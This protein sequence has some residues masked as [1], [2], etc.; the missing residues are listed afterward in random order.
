MSLD[1]QRWRRLDVLLKDAITLVS[2]DDICVVLTEFDKKRTVYCRKMKI[3]K[4]ETQKDGNNSFLS[5]RNT[6]QRL[7]RNEGIGRDESGLQFNPR[8][9]FELEF[10]QK[11]IRKKTQ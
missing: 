10:C 6:L 9:L 5:L 3:M 11:N 1:R 7:K 8:N 2:G 4:E